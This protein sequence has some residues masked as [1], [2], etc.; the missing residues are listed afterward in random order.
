MHL[1]HSFQ[2]ESGCKCKRIFATR[3]PQRLLGRKSFIR[4]E[5]LGAGG[6]PMDMADMGNKPSV[7]ESHFDNLTIAKGTACAGN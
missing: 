2:N 1:G 5:R 3:I 7:R 6:A 4:L